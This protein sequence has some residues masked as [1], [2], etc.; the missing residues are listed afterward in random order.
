[1]RRLFVILIASGLVL[2]ACG[3]LEINVYQTPTPAI[4]IVS[5]PLNDTSRSDPDPLGMVYFWLSKPANDPIDPSRRLINIARLPGSCIVGRITCPPLEEIETPFEIGN[6]GPMPFITWSPDGTIVALPGSAEVAGSATALYL[7]EP[8]KNSW[9]ELAQ[10]PVVDYVIWSPDSQWIAMRVQD[11][12]GNVDVFVIHPD[13]SGLRNL[14]DTNL[15]DQGEPSFVTVQSWV[16]G[17]VI[18]GTRGVSDEGSPA[19]YFV[20]PRTG[21]VQNTLY[22]LT[23]A[24]FASPDNALVTVKSIS[25]D[26]SSLEFIHDD[27]TTNYSIHSLKD[28]YVMN[29]TWAADGQKMAYL[30]SHDSFSDLSR[31]IVVANKDGS[32]LSQYPTDKTLISLVFS[33]DGKYLLADDHGSLYIVDLESSKM[34]RFPG[35]P[36]DWFTLYSSWQPPVQ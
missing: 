25:S 14:T 20:D 27:G 10:F 35:I 34:D 32:N 33:P 11:G 5:V 22:L 15:P 26:A 36:S 23:Y 31:V 29:L 1:M 2:S 3:T 13:G 21:S 18:I 7:Y 19:F 6:E 28:S 12:L 9:K 16:N 4:P 17:N 24:I 8:Q 30:V